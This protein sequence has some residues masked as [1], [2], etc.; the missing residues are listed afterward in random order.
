MVAN[1][2]SVEERVTIV[3]GGGTGIGKQIAKRFAEAGAPVVIASRK[4]ENLEGVRKEILAAGGRALALECDVRDP[5]QVQRV[6]DRTVEEYGR[7]DVLVNNHGASFRC[8]ILDMSPNA[9]NTV[10]AINL[11]GTFLF[12]RAAGLVMRDAGAGSIINISSTAGVNGSPSM[13][14]YGAAKAG[15]INFTRSL[16]DELAPHGIRV[17]C[18]AP[19]PIITEG[20]LEVLRARGEV[21]SN[22]GAGMVMN[23]WG[24][25]DEIAYPVMFLASDASTFMTGETIVIDGGGRTMRGMEG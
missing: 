8:N 1:V 20:F 24:E 6:V 19:G 14:H 2:F 21:P 12:S 11:N 4:L 18:I 15:V 25:C 10:V 13:A 3:T 9:W 7:I 17:N 5:E 23:R 16:A 22:L